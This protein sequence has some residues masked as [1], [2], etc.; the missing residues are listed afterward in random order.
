MPLILPFDL[1]A[2][3]LE[4]L[5]VTYLL[6]LTRVSALLMATPVFRSTGVPSRIRLLLAVT[7]AA[8]TVGTLPPGYE[9]P[10]F[11]FSLI[12]IALW[13]MA[14]GLAM[15]LCIQMVF[16]ALTIAGE[17]VA[18][19][20]GLG[21]ATIVDPQNGASVPTMSQ[22]FVLLGTMLFV[23]I[24]GHL[25]ALNMVHDSFVMLPPGSQGNLSGGATPL[26]EWAMAMYANALRLA[27]PVIAAMLL[28]NLAFGVITRAAPQLNVFAVGFPLM[29]LIGMAA[30]MINIG[31]LLDATASLFEQAF[32]AAGKLFS[33][34]QG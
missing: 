10:T 18:V 11:G 26:L 34:A 5:V 27:L 4:G 6:A 15:G 29:M 14:L 31:T 17:C 22:Q 24:N 12:P 1:A 8:L 23:A 16:A 19:G 32:E 13:E 20:M 30:V 28:T 21:F 33:G 25:V 2:L 9:V 3:N 7:V